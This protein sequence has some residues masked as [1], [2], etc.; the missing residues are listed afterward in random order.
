[1]IEQLG[2]RKF[3]RITPTAKDVFRKFTS[4]PF[5]FFACQPIL[6]AFKILKDQK[7]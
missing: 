7:Q 6:V 3:K 5:F 1:M 2:F 4:P